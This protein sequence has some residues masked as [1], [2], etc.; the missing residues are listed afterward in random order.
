M[1]ERIKNTLS[2]DIAG[3]SVANAADRQASE[4]AGNELINRP[5][6]PAVYA[7]AGVSHV[8]S[9]GDDFQLQGR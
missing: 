6:V 1:L 5:T 8:S 3:L 4:A 2:E 7:Q 9:Q